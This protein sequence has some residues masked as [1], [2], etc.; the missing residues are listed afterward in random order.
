MKNMNDSI[1][2][3]NTYLV[4]LITQIILLMTLLF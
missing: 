1:V 2:L 4:K 3:A